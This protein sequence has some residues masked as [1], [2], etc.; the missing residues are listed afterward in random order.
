MAISVGVLCI[1]HTDRMTLGVFPGC[2]FIKSMTALMFKIHLKCT[3][4]YL[5]IKANS[6]I[7]TIFA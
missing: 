1:G 4:L 5:F 7:K 6:K 2:V 3:L